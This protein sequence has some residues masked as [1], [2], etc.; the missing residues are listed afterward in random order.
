LCDQ[1]HKN[2]LYGRLY[3]NCHLHEDP[4]KDNFAK[5]SSLRKLNVYH[6]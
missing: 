1:G 6:I 2:Y 4:Y 5:R 3:N